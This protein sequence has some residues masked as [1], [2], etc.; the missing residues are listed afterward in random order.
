[1]PSPKR[2]NY[3]NENSYQKARANYN[4][5]GKRSANK[6]PELEKLANERAMIQRRTQSVIMLKNLH[7]ALKGIDQKLA[8]NLAQFNSQK[9]T[10]LMLAEARKKVNKNPLALVTFS[11]IKKRIEN[12]HSTRYAQARSQANRNKRNVHEHIAMLQKAIAANKARMN[13]IN[14]AAKELEERIQKNRLA[15]K[16]AREAALR[17]Q[18]IQNRM[19]ALL[20]KSNKNLYKNVS[21]NNLQFF[22]NTRSNVYGN[23]HKNKANK[24]ERIL[25]ARREFPAFKQSQKG[26]NVIAKISNLKTARLTKRMPQF[27]HGFLNTL[28]QQ[29]S[30]KYAEKFVKNVESKEKRNKLMAAARQT[31]EEARIIHSAHGGVMGFEV[32]MR[33]PPPAWNYLQRLPETSAEFNLHVGHMDPKVLHQLVEQAS[34]FWQYIQGNNQYQENLPPAPPVLSPRPANMSIRTYNEF[35]REY[36]IKAREWLKRLFRVLIRWKRNHPQ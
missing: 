6:I 8:K 31:R 17:R 12:I 10:N 16:A 9:R 24:F 33:P 22:I 32:N 23:A 28:R 7:A 11:Q 13:A 30:R 19:N 5:K 34:Q 36:E 3:P 2:E 25:K 4:R 20:A 14:K 15:A 18:T 29:Q 35:K 26:Q 27:V 21:N 1:M